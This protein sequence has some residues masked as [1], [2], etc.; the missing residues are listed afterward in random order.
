MKKQKTHMYVLMQDFSAGIFDKN[1]RD[2]EKQL[3][4]ILYSSFFFYFP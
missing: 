3:T 4:F 2:K 1:R